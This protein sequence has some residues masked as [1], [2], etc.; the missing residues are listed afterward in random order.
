[1]RPLAASTLNDATPVPGTFGSIFSSAASAT[2][3]CTPR[4]VSGPERSTHVTTRYDGWYASRPRG[5]RRQAAP[6]A[7]DA[8]GADGR[9]ANAGCHRGLTPVSGAPAADR[10]GRSARVPTGHRPDADPR[11]PHADGGDGSAPHAPPHSRRRRGRSAGAAV[12]TRAT[13]RGGADRAGGAAGTWANEPAKT[14]C[15]GV[16]RR[17]E[18]GQ[19]SAF[20][21]EFPSVKRHSVSRP[22]V[23]VCACRTGLVR[24]PCDPRGAAQR[25]VRARAFVFVGRDGPGACGW[26]DG[27]DGANDHTTSSWCV[28]RQ[29]MSRARRARCSH[30]DS[31]TVLPCFSRVLLS[32]G[33]PRRKLR[34][35]VRHPVA[36]PRV[37][38]AGQSPR[39][40]DRRDPL[41]PPLRDGDRPRSSRRGRWRLRPQ[42]LPCRLD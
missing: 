38:H 41:A 18:P 35:V 17:A 2:A 20:P 31:R 21:M 32:R 37:E 13:A 27:A 30:L 11:V 34:G 14:A 5:L 24:C 3:I 23:F 40:R 7:A 29:E 15:G 16:A 28:P 39:Q 8:P 25:S 6:A 36:P 26:Y 10:R 42:D 19:T 22:A 1:M 33:P 4:A 12:G 9:R